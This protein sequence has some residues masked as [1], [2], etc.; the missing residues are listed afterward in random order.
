MKPSELPLASPLHRWLFVPGLTRI[1]MNFA[2]PAGARLD[3]RGRH[4]S[5]ELPLLY[6]VAGR[7]GVAVNRYY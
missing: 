3:L 6:S 4:H 7:L 1:A 5:H 2:I